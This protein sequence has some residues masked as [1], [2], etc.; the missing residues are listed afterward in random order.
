[1]ITLGTHLLATKSFLTNQSNELDDS[2]SVP[3][4]LDRKSL[5]LKEVLSTNADNLSSELSA[6]KNAL[7][8]DI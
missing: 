2:F 5:S 7:L 6:D 3:L 1:M 4:T 8:P